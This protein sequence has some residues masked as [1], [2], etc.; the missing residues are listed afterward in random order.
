M[1][2]SKQDTPDSADKK[3]DDDKNNNDIDTFKPTFIR[4]SVDPDVTIIIGDKEFKEYSH[5]LRSWSGYFDTALSSGMKEE[6]SLKF[7]FP[8]RSPTEW[9]WIVAL[10]APMAQEKV[11]MENLNIALDWFDFL[12]CEI[13]LRVCDQILLAHLKS[14][15][16]AFFLYNLSK[17]AEYLIMSVKY[18][19]EESKAFCFSIM[20]DA[21]VDT[22]NVLL[23]DKETLK[24]IGDLVKENVEC[25]NKLMGP[26]K[27][28]LP[29]SISEEKAET[30]LENDLLHEMIYL[31]IDK[32]IQGRIKPRYC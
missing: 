30:L 23:F 14:K 28:H 9:Q 13:A 16:A 20:C 32:V 22:W 18:N 6:T 7:E 19:L 21:L 8:D 12:C 27:T 5:T 15:K 17:V 2:D 11:T 29:S 26:L 4:T 24:N 10:M 3:Q 31:A 1:L 25:R